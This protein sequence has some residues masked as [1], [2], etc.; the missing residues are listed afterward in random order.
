MVFECIAGVA[1]AAFATVLTGYFGRRKLTKLALMDVQE[2]DLLRELKCRGFDIELHTFEAYVRK[3]YKIV[4]KL[5]EGAS[6]EVWKVQK[7]QSSDFYA[8]K[9]IK[10]SHSDAALQTEVRCL[11]KLQHRH[12]VNLVEVVDTRAKMWL[13]MEYAHGGNIYERI[14]SLRHFSE[15]HASRIIKQVLKAVHYMHSYGIVHRDLKPENVLMMSNDPD[16]DVKVAD[17]G[18]AV[19]LNFE[20]YR[21]DESMRLKKATCIH[22]GYCGSPICMA[23]EVASRHAQYGPQCD[24]W[25][26]GCMTYEL[27]TGNPPFM[28]ANVQ[29][30]FK[31]IQTAESP[32]FNR[33][34]W[35]GISENAKDI[36]TKMLKKRPD[37]RV[38][39]RE[40]LSHVWFRQAPTTHMVQAHTNIVRRVTSSASRMTSR[41]TSHNGTIMASS[42]S[43]QEIDV[44]LSSRAKS[45]GR[46]EDEEEEEEEED[47]ENSDLSNR[48]TC[49][50]GETF[51]PRRRSIQATR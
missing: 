49:E 40:A 12:I 7:A 45:T 15:Q 1:S 22:E 30:L 39:A 46:E 16:S 9:E 42:H 33:G 34:V 18:L 47:Q 31:M 17:F 41:I 6:G 11:R 4:E 3:N 44:F 24:V 27:L 25:S 38:S 36:V 21:P 23:P 35:D 48:I 20:G 26:V 37:D 19:E 13:V 5:G 10:K 43:G 50:D 2:K 14:V 8:M 32:P 28:A 51:H 29:L